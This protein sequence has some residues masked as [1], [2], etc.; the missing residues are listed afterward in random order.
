MHRF[1]QSAIVRYASATALVGLAYAL[2]LVLYVRLE[3]HV[4]LLFMAAVMV[5]A[6]HGGLG[7][8]LLA[9]LLSAVLVAYRFF[10]EPDSFT[11]VGDD[12]LAMAIFVAVALL[13][14]WLSAG[15]RREHENQ[16]YRDRLKNLASELSAAEERHRRQTASALH[17]S[18][19]HPLAISVMKIRQSLPD[20]PADARRELEQACGLL[21]QTIQQTRSLTL[22]LSPPI[23]Y[24]L[25]L[26][27]ACEWL[28]EQFQANHGLHV[29]VS[30][31]GQPKPT[32]EP[33]RAL[34]FSV[35]R[36]LLINVVKHAHARHVRIAIQRRGD[37]I[38][39]SV[40][41]DGVGFAPDQLRHDAGGGFGLFNIRE[42][43]SRLGGQV[44]VESIPGRGARVVV[45]APLGEPRGHP[46]ES[47]RSAAR[48]V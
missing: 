42:R 43:L 30:D 13:V 12:L 10:G 24:E 41:D 7:P 37:C 23:L 14:S 5:A 28:G 38:A 17:D 21:E 3:H 22:Q 9:G 26:E 44:R 35:V 4:L 40:E 29:E 15:R 27:P 46:P 45:M 48:T 11:L 20:C 19:G 25:G 18:I 6:I 32:D 47:P 2:T 16:A 1:L 8:G 31:D 36:E 39:I 33:T 34:L